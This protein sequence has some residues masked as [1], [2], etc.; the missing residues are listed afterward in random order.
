MISALFRNT[1]PGVCTGYLWDTVPG[2][3]WGYWD[4]NL[5]SSTG[6]SSQLLYYCIS[7]LNTYTEHDVLHTDSLVKNR[8]SIFL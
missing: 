1:V 4:T 2:V 3:P 8:K 5:G 7:I 6:M